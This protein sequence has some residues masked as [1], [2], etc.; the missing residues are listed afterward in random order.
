ME[1]IQDVVR[2][3]GI[4]RKAVFSLALLDRTAARK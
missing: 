4:G 1:T 3:E 2:N